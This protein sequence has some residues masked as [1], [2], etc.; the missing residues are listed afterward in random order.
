MYEDP[1]LQGTVVGEVAFEDHAFGQG[2]SS[3]NDPNEYFVRW[4]GHSWA[5]LGTTHPEEV[6]LPYN[7]QQR[8]AH[9]DLWAAH[10]GTARQGHYLDNPK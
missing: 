6:I 4:H 7:D 8:V 2:G 9:V 3:P 5:L 1:T 10:M